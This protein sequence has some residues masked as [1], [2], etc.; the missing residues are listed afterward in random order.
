MKRHVFPDLSLRRKIQRRHLTQDLS[1][2]IQGAQVVTPQPPPLS[3]SP[4]EYVDMNSDEFID[5]LKDCSNCRRMVADLARA[6]QKLSSR[7]LVAAGVE[8]LN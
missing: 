3:I 7:V 1:K 4:D 8:V 5:H 6:G 2:L